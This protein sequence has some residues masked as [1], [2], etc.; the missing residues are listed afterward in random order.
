MK[1]FTYYMS[2]QLMKIRFIWCAGI[3]IAGFL[4]LLSFLASGQG[5]LTQTTAAQF[6]KGY[7]N[8]TT[9]TADRIAMPYKATAM[10]YWT[11]TTTLPRRV[12][13]HQAVTWNNFVYVTGGLDVVAVIQGIEKREISRK[14]YRSTVN[15]GLGSW[16]T[17]G[18]LPEGIMEHASVIAN[19]YLYVIGGINE[20]TVASDKIYRA[21]IRADGSLRNWELNGTNLPMPLWG[22]TADFVNGYI[23]ITGGSNQDDTTAI[24]NVYSVR[25]EPN[26]ELTTFTAQ[27]SLGI[28]RNQHATAVYDNRLFVLGG[29]DENNDITNT[30][31]YTDVD[32]SGTCSAWQSAANLPEPLFGLTAACEQG[33]LIVSG[34]YNDTLGF[35]VQY[36]YNTDV[37]AGTSFTWT[38]SAL[39]YVHFANAESFIT[40][41]Y[42]YMIGGFD[43]FNVTMDACYFNQLNIS[44]TEKLTEGNFLGEVFDLGLNRHVDTLYFGGVDLANYAMYYRTAQ[45]AGTWGAWTDIT[46]NFVVAINAN[47]RYVQYLFNVTGAPTNNTIALDT[48]QLRFAAV[49]LAGHYNNETWT[50]ANSP[51]W[52]SGD[53]FIDGTVNVEAGVSFSFSEGVKME[54]NGILNC[55]GTSG[56]PITFTSFTGEDGYWNGLHF[57][58]SS[59]NNISTLDYVII[60]NAGFV[61]HAGLNCFY[62]NQPTMNNGTIRYCT[63]SALYCDNGRPVFNTPLFHNNENYLIRLMNVSGPVFNNETFSANAINKVK[64]LGGTLAYNGYWDNV[65]DE[66]IVDATAN[67]SGYTLV[68][69]KG[70]DMKF[71]PNTGINVVWGAIQA[72]GSLYPDSIISFTAQNG[73]PGGWNGIYIQYNGASL[74][75]YCNVSHAMNNI[76]T[77]SAANVTVERCNLSYAANHGMVIS[78]STNVTINYS[79]FFNNTQDG[80]YA[81]G[82]CPN[83]LVNNSSFHHN[84]RHGISS[85]CTY[86]L[87]NCHLYNNS[88][89]GLV[90]NDGNTYQPQIEN[91][92]IENNVGNGIW[93]SDCW[94][95]FINVDVVNNGGHGF[96]MNANV[97]LETYNLTL[98][99]NATNDYRISG[100]S[101]NRDI[102]WDPGDYPYI[103]IGSFSVTTSRLTLSKG[104]TLQ[105]APGTSLN[106]GTVYWAS[107]Q[108]WAEGVNHPDSVITFTALNGQPGGW[109]GIVFHGYT[110]SS[111]LKYCIIEKAVNINVSAPQNSVSVEYCTIKNAGG[112]GIT[113]NNSN[114][115]ID[116][117]EVFGNAGNGIEIYGSAL[118]TNSHIYNNT[119]TGLRLNDGNV[120]EPQIENVVIENNQGHGIWATDCWPDIINVD[121][122]NNTGHGFLMNANVWP[123]AYDL[124][125]S[126]NATNDYRISGGSVARN[127][128]WEPADYPYIV[129]GAFSVY[130]GRLTLSKG[131]TLQFAP[132]TSINVGPAYWASGQ[133]WAE[134]V[135]HPDSVITFTA[136]NGQPGG[137]DGIVFHGYT[138][139][140]LLKY[141][142]IEK[143]VNINVSAPQNSVSVE[144]CTIKNAGGNGISFY[145]SNNLIDHCEVFGNA[146]NGLEV[147]GSALITNTHIYNNTG[148]GLR[149]NDGSAWE[150]QIENV[151]IENNQGNGILATDCWPDFINVDVL[152]NTG[153]GFLMNANV[154]PEANDLVLS[155]NATNDYRIDGGSIVRNMTWEP[156]DYPYIVI[157]AFSVNN[158]RLTLSKGLTLSFAPGTSISVGNA[159]WAS[160]SLWAEGV[161][162]PDSLIT[163]T[164][165]NGQPGGW[166]GISFNSYTGPSLLKYCTI[167]KAQSANISVNYTSAPVFSNCLISQSTGYG[168]YSWYGA[169]RLSNSRVVNNQNNGIFIGGNPVPTIGDTL[170][171]GNDIF[172]NYQYEIYNQSTSNV[173]ARHNF[174]NVPDLNTAGM[175]IYDNADNPSYGIVMIDPMSSSSC[176]AGNWFVSA[177]ARYHNNDSTAMNNVTVVLRDNLNA[178]VDSCLTSPEGFST[179]NGVANGNYSL[180]GSTGKP[181]AGVNATDALLVMQHY[182]SVINLTG[183]RLLAG[184]VNAS[185]S[186]NSTDALA[187][188]QRFAHI[189]NSFPAGDWAFQSETSPL[190]IN[191]NSL[192][193]KYWAL[194][195]GDVNGSNVPGG[196]KSTPLITLSSGGQLVADDIHVSLPV[197]YNNTSP[198]GA[199][200]LRIAYPSTYITITGVSVNNSTSNVI[201][202]TGDGVLSIAWCNLTPY[203]PGSGNPLLNIQFTINDAAVFNSGL[204]L[205][206]TGDNELADNNAQSID[207]VSLTYPEIVSQLTQ[208]GQSLTATFGA[209]VNQNSE[210]G[211]SVSYQL[212]EDG[213][214]TIDLFSI[215][216]ALCEKIH[217]G[218]CKAGVYTY[219]LSQRKLSKGIYYIKL[220]FTGSDTQKELM[221]KVPVL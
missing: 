129:I 166:N 192:N 133:L 78:S 56:S 66:Y 51:Y 23:V 194:C 11:Q 76:A 32:V 87:L 181:W 28:K 202:H 125:M 80:L 16:T 92:L 60:E 147:Y 149:L 130:S 162:H 204:Q 88:G 29:F 27:P 214:I 195:Y 140:S 102:T 7:F 59:N 111:L 146:G 8:N 117:C 94:P 142:I 70:V 44:G 34:G 37:T 100:G 182:A 43:I 145:N 17:M 30:V 31:V 189:T 48:V 33:R 79:D 124:V 193:T 134:G 156:A 208:I 139:S 55:N 40:G 113:F 215:N 72:V 15:N 184:D 216:G 18:D 50:L 83:L 199:V 54:V 109:D 167:E 169:Y 148:T 221:V 12:Q 127:I 77:S 218:S 90:L 180:S 52:V 163:F 144:Y 69:E 165:L 128:T 4:F 26:G 74:L 106:V 75:K 126:G 172:N 196:S 71:A 176:L 178:P 123:E 68:I 120:W 135:N 186:V 143:A 61:G 168:I 154:M 121:V 6:G 107:G 173:Y 210:N 157:G 151:V 3:F 110:S 187:I 47:I 200:S 197:Y 138:S 46:N 13:N 203:M 122:F 119:G 174:F 84:T 183:I 206:L 57:S 108:L 114:N 155:G 64:V 131:L 91:V 209:W 38:Q 49:Q 65:C 86:I 185:S 158:G 21:K 159:Y 213:R 9:V 39:Y 97:W 2:L 19:G 171:K 175:R 212:P 82:N 205:S 62:T 63:N 217:T 73:T 22:H 220:H 153:H 105:F 188:L 36:A 42:L 45:H 152:N 207:N 177:L 67:T 161:N 1:Q 201:Y 81:E 141:C 112:N 116:H 115:R 103:V 191:D 98:S 5:V 190:V 170:G 96:L 53:V 104:L 198:V 58:S 136:L 137:W 160:G 41:G 93:A 25:V 150:P 10:N 179:F 20:D 89:S 35:S 95:D 219:N 99:G 132:G 85:G 211:T 164:A 118:I 101:I 24:N 14:V